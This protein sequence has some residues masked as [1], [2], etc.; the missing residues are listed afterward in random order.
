MEK[1]NEFHHL[2]LHDNFAF[3]ENEKEK[4][5]ENHDHYNKIKH[6][7]ERKVIKNGYAHNVVEITTKDNFNLSYAQKALI[8]D[9]GNLCFGYSYLGNNQFKIFT[10]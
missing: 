8:A 6:M 9:N 1:L 5:K 7:A 10:D 4:S 2:P 3:T